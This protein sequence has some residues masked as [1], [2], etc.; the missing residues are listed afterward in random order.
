MHV[1]AAVRAAVEDVSREV[2]LATAAG[3]GGATAGLQGAWKR[4]VDL[5]DLGP[6]PAYR[7]CPHCGGVG[8]LLATRC[9]VCWESLSPLAPA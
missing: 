1:E 8:M 3:A 2:A 7:T 5:M 4:L 9:G 6:A